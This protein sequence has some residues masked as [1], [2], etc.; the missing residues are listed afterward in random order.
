MLVLINISL[1]V[2]YKLIS[3]ICGIRVFTQLG[4]CYTI[5]ALYEIDFII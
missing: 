5:L 1:V 3:N 2:L 4:Q